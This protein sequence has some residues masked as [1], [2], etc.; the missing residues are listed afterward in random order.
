MLS[1]TQT[2]RLGGQIVGRQC[3]VD[4]EVFFRVNPIESGPNGLKYKSVNFLINM[5]ISALNTLL[6]PVLEKITA[7][8]RCGDDQPVALLRC[9]RSPGC[10]DGDQCV[11]SL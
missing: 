2:A 10:F 7:S 5:F 8:L 6:G 4:L 11:V 3:F 9:S 1:G